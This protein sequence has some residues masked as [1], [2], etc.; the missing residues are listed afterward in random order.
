MIYRV[1][2]RIRSPADFIRTWPIKRLW[3]LK[4]VEFLD[5][6]MSML[7]CIGSCACT[8]VLAIQHEW[9]LTYACSLNDAT[10]FLPHGLRHSRR[11][12]MLGFILTP[13]DILLVCDCVT[14]R[15]FIYSVP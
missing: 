9:N 12:I 7:E 1:S 13:R 15:K 3:I 6:Y 11:V 10:Q 2:T 5:A 14:V 8:A 4:A